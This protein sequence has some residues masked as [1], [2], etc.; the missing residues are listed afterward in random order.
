MSKVITVQFIKKLLRNIVNRKRLRCLISHYIVFKV[1]SDIIFY[2]TA[3]LFY[4][5]ELKILLLI[6][7]D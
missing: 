5:V 4:T 3:N 6:I 1:G 7:K 2:I